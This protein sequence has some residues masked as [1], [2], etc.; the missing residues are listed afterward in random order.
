[1]DKKITIIGGGLAGLTA[2]T[3]L[4]KKGLRVQLLEAREQD[5]RLLRYHQCQGFTFN[6][7]A[8]CLI[9]PDVLDHAFARLG[10]DREA[11]LPLRKIT[12]SHTT[13]L[14][15]G[16]TVTMGEG[17]D[18]RVEGGGEDVDADQ[19]RGELER[20]V[21]KWSPVLDFF[22]KDAAFHPFSLGRMALRGWKHLPKLIG[23]ADDELKTSFSSRAVRAA[24]SGALLFN[25]VP[26]E[27]M[28]VTMVLGLV[29]M[30]RDGYY[31]PEGGM[32]TIT[33]TL[34]EAFVKNGGEI[35]LNAPVERIIVKDGRVTSVTAA[36][37]GVIESPVVLSTTSGMTTILSLL[38]AADAPARMR[39]KAHKA[40]LSHR[41]FVLQLGLSNAIAAPSHFMDELP[42]M[43][44]QDR[45]FS[46]ERGG[47]RLVDLHC[48]DGDHAGACPAG[49]MH[50]RAVPA[51]GGGHALIRL[52][53]ECQAAHG[54]ERHREAEAPLPA[55][56]RGDAPHQPARFPGADA[57]VPGGFVRLISGCGTAG[58]VPAQD[59]TPR[60]IPG[61]ADH[62]PRV[63]GGCG[64]H[65]GR[66]RGR[67]DSREYLRRIPRKKSCRMGSAHPATLFRIL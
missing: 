64:S 66:L 39:G 27:K 18:V 43:E 26:P 51:G 67:C 22:T 36:G 46:Q 23:S 60:A 30:L 32:G 63:W 65:V 2:G 21:A 48:P 58:D 9:L 59:A 14:P 62:L 25:G 47:G 53:R 4:A 5:R 45:L 11:C 42:F 15:D 34:R 33:D 29:S 57:P 37:V 1:M 20:M 41:S 50:H 7:G 16:T 17:L 12:A 13:T 31:L 49:W 61:R 24:F 10:L 6:D 8:L 35:S 56:D 44:E 55:A 28:P 19:L 3:L 38:D 40:P 54:G 52:G